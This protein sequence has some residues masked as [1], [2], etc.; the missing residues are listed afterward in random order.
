[1]SRRSILV[2]LACAVVSFIAAPERAQASPQEVLG[3]GY[4]STAMGRS[5]AAVG[6]GVDAVYANPALLSLSQSMELEL[7]LMGASFDLHAAGAGMPGRISYQ[8]LRASTLG[9][10]V[11]IPFGG[12]LKDRVALGIGFVTPLDV[13]VRGRILYPE[14]PQFLLADRVQSVALQGGIGIDVGYGIRIGGGVGALAALEGSVL[15]AR[16]ASGRIGT[17]VEDT[18]VAS[19]APV[20]GA[21]YDIG[22]HYRVGLAFRGELEGRFNVVITAED[23]GE[24]DIPP[25]NISG[26][27]QYD[28]WQLALELARIH[29]PWRVAVGV[30]YKHWPAYPG[31]LE[32]TV[33]CEDA[34]VELDDC[35]APV[36]PD[37]GYAPVVA[38]HVGV[39]RVLGSGATEILLRGG[40]AFEPTPAPE[41]TGRSRYFD[42]HRSIFSAGWGVVLPEQIAPV[43][44]DG[45]VQMQLLHSRQH[46]QRVVDG[47]LADATVDT[48][49]W[50]GA[51]GIAG[52]VH[53]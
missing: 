31:P 39:E 51:A 43:A 19:Y 49:G 36:P 33:R 50:I 28:P 38:P 8:G 6:Q 22:E 41:Q 15:V 3:F 23:L 25:L 42:N 47:A 2:A 4:R 5:G 17:V 27:A 48:H 34:D 26:V 9:G 44:F 52:R 18:L 10:V 35:L 53:F 7:G 16:D 40:Y 24:I 30:T 13:V 32:A 14:T 45:Y 1:M 12:A 37:P 29:G 11:P 20:A 21:S 46:E